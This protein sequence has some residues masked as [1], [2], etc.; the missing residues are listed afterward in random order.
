MGVVGKE[1]NTVPCS[2]KRVCTRMQAGAVCAY[3]YTHM[4]VQ[5]NVST[6]DFT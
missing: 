2:Q 1:L 6:V 3:N 4:R 5:C